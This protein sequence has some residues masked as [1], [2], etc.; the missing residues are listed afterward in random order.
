VRI[1]AGQHTS[2]DQPIRKHGRHVL[3]AVNGQIDVGV[4]QRILDLFDEQSLAARFRQRRFLQPVSGRS[5][6]HNLA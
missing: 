5:D 2:D 6:D 3:A 1:F 4:Q